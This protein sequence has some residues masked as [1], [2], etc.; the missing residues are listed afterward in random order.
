MD[1]RV[2]AGTKVFSPISG[3]IRISAYR[4]E[5][6]RKP[7]K[8]EY[9]RSPFR[10]KPQ[11]GSRYVE[12]AVTDESGRIWMFRHLDPGELPP[13][14]L[15]KERA[16]IPVRAGEQ[17][18]VVVAWNAPILPDPAIYHHMHFEILDPDGY[19]FNP[20][21]ILKPLKDSIP[22][23]IHGVWFVPDE[24]GKA[25]PPARGGIPT[26]RGG[27]DIVAGIT[28]SADGNRYIH[29]AYKIRM[30]IRAEAGE[31]VVP[32]ADIVEWD[33]LPIKG[34]RTQMA[35]VLYKES[36]TCDR[37]TIESNGNQGPRFFLNILTNGDRK[38][39]YSPGYCFQTKNVPDGRY[40]V[41][42]EASDLNGNTASGTWEF[43]VKNH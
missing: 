7:L 40:F 22:P 6:S 34:D 29:S 8:F 43:L 2:P 16:G 19:Y 28:D 32:D 3:K 5:A 17:L 35:T 14:L 42:I 38:N 15:E 36:L 25:F 27:I 26:V 18:G 21:A 30:G 31:Q 10:Q 41:D 1:L 11:I 13:D 39:G 12:I 20:A 9:L 23:V 37:K 4:I 33:R 24:G